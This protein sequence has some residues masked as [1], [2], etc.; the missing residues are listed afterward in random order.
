VEV[1]SDVGCGGDD[2]VYMMLARGDRLEPWRVAVAGG[3]PQPL[4]P[5]PWVALVPAPRGRGGLYALKADDTFV[6]VPPGGSLA[7]AGLR[8]AP[9]A[10][11]LTWAADGDAVL[12]A[13]A[14]S[15]CATTS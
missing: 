5:P 12:V 3:V 10:D 1:V 14:A 9:A 15:S 7:D 6:V 11:N 13:R 4:A 8:A 2:F